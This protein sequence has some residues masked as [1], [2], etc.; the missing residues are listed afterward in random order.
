M[1]WSPPAG[2]PLALLACWACGGGVVDG[3]GEPDIE[4][5]SVPELGS[6]ALLHG[7][8]RH[9]DPATYQV[10]IAARGAGPWTVTT[11]RIRGDGSWSADVTSE[12]DDPTAIY[13]FLVGDPAALDGLEGATGFPAELLDPAPIHDGVL[14]QVDGSRRVLLFS[15]R[16]WIVRR[17]LV[18]DEPGPN[19]FT[20]QHQAA[21]VDADGVLHLNIVRDD[22]EYL[23]SEVMLTQRL[24]HG[25]FVWSLDSSPRHRNEYGVTGLFVRDD[26]APT[27]AKEFDIEMA[28]WGDPDGP[29][30]QFAVA[31]WQHTGNG[32]KYTFGPLWE[33][34]IHAVTWT[35]GALDFG[36]AEGA[37]WP[38]A[39]EDVLHTWSYRG[40]DV[41]VEGDN[42]ARINLWTFRFFGL[43]AGAGD[44][45]SLAVRRFDFDPE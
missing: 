41:P 4:I 5:T 24:G 3:E 9:I 30:A 15:G 45:V 18:P 34:T 22:D 35:E 29:D 19:V 40:P 7:Q 37:V 42:R 1:R 38:P 32:D 17:T 13:A 10:V 25:T 16:E 36:S 39:E 44:D 6:H 2:S 8:A 23:S 28:R 20:D 21:T 12:I 31:P 26:T 14:R 43:P 27:D 11:E 33:P